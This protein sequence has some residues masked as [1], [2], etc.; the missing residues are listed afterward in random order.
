MKV[1]LSPT[2]CPSVWAGHCYIGRAC[3]L[4]AAL[5]TSFSGHLGGAV[6]HRAEYVTMLR[7]VENYLHWKGEKRRGEEM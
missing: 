4:P 1:F 6:S 5:F 3:L 7:I 2:Q